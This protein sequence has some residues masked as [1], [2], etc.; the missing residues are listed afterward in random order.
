MYELN[1]IL[2]KIKALT[3]ETIITITWS[4]FLRSWTIIAIKVNGIANFKPNSSGIKDPKIIPNIV[5][6]CQLIQRVIPAPI[7]W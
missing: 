3:P 6:I 5:E 1:G 4:I 2:Y 7:I